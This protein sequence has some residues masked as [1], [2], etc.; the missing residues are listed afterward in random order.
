MSVLSLS[1]SIIASVLGVAA[2]L[3]AMKH[4]RELQVAHTETHTLRHET[5]QALGLHDILVQDTVLLDTIREIG[6]AYALINEE[7][8]PFF[9]VLAPG[10]AMGNGSPGRSRHRCDVCDQA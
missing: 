7:R 8:D 1:L 6:S 4:L 10:C 3:I 2:L 5:L 9:Q